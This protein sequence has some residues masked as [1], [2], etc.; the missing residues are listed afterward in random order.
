MQTQAVRGKLERKLEKRSGVA[1]T[2]GSLSW[3]PWTGLQVRNV[4]V[5]APR[6]GDNQASR[7]LCRAELDVKLHWSSLLRGALDLRE[8]RVRKGQI[9]IPME[10]LFLL[11]VDTDQPKSAASGPSLSLIHI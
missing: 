11:P 9:A 10:L 4:T 3:T 8:V 1:W 5:D 6:M 7:F 2:I